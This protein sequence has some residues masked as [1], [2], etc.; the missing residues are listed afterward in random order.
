MKRNHLASSPTPPRL[1][2]FPARAV[3][4]SLGLL[5]A[6]CGG[7]ED[8]SAV[9]CAGTGT[10]LTLVAEETRFDNNCL[11]VAADTAFTITLDNRQDLGHNVSITTEGSGEL[12]FRGDLIPGVGTETYEIPALPAGRYNFICDPHPATMRGVLVVE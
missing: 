2:R 8:L 6:A 5:A 9:T 4:A 11:A 3:V 1:R 12:K 10:Q 7:G